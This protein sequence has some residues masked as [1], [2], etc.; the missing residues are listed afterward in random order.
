MLLCNLASGKKDFFGWFGLFGF[1]KSVYFV[2]GGIEDH[3]G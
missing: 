3:G 1:F 2:G